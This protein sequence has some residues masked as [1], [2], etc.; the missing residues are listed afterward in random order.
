MASALDAPVG[1]QEHQPASAGAQCAPPARD[2]SAPRARVLALAPPQN[3]V[4]HAGGARLT[5]QLV[6]RSL[7]RRPRRARGCRVYS[8]W[9]RPT[10]ASARTSGSRASDP[11][12]SAVDRAVH[13]DADTSECCRSSETRSRPRSCGDA[14][15]SSPA[16]HPAN[17]HSTRHRRRSAPHSHG[18]RP[19]GH[20]PS[21][22]PSSRCA[23]MNSRLTSA[24]L[25]PPARAVAAQRRPVATSTP[26]VAARDHCSGRLPASTACSGS[27]SQMRN[28]D[29]ASGL[30]DRPGIERAHLAID[31]DRGARPVD[32]RLLLA[33][34]RRIRRTRRPVARAACMCPSRQSSSASQQRL[35]AE[36]CEVDHAGCAAVSRASIGVVRSSSIGPVSRPSSICMIVTPVRDRPPAAH[37]GSAPRRASAADSDAWMFRQPRRGICRTAGGQEQPISHDDHEIGGPRRRGVPATVGSRSV[38]G[39][40]T[41]SPWRARSSLTALMATRRPRP[42]GRSG[43][44]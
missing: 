36:H 11:D 30:G 15:R 20:E 34:F 41:G 26:S 19:T 12:A 35:G 25:R 8:N 23:L 10:I 24:C 22:A 13:R 42:A 5:E 6:P 43:W 4:D 33:D 44:V 37:A 3:R 32:Q 1:C 31:F 21:T 38:A 40:S 14:P 28:C 18:L 17:G 39:C 7:S 27:A 16:P 2:R 9:H 29:P